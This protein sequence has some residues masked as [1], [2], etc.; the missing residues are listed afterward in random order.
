MPAS[1]AS[2]RTR[3]APAASSSTSRSIT[4]SKRRQPGPRRPTASSLSFAASPPKPKQQAKLSFA[5]GPQFEQ[6]YCPKKRVKIEGQPKYGSENEKRASGSQ[7]SDEQLWSVL[8]RPRNRS[9]L[10][11]HSRKVQD[12]EQW[13]TDAFTGTP[14]VKK[15][16][17]LLVLTGP[18]GAAKTETLRQ[19]A[20][21]DEL[22][23]EI[24]EYKAEAEC[25]GKPWDDHEGVQLS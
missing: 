24:T 13:L 20:A 3:F 7:A 22:D 16:R 9:E 4:Q 8:Y 23:F 18:A 5:S 25:G 19:L 11:V 6:S 12:V 1:R 21:P 17:R 10:A 15:L 2:S 14:S